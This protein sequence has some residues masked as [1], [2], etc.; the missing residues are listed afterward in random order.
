MA[1]T[2][3]PQPLT[4]ESATPRTRGRSTTP[5]ARVGV[6]VSDIMTRTV[7]TAHADT[8]LPELIDQM[9]H[10]GV[11]GIPIVDSDS[12]LVGIVTEADLISKPAYGGRRHRAL[13]VI[14]D[15][16]RGREQRWLSKAT[17]ATAGQIMSTSVATAAPYET[18]QTAARLMIEAGVKRLPVVD[19]EHLVGIISRADVLR[20]MHRSDEELQGE[21][22]SALRDPVRAPENALVE[23]TVADGVVTL[24]GT[25]PF[26][27]D[28]PVLSAVVWR[29]PGVVDVRNELT[30]EEPNPEPVPTHT[31]DYD[32]F[33]FL[34]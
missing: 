30:P 6:R 33:H 26:P 5:G 13:A 15:L 4:A 9:L 31:S 22:T 34:R 19:G 16:L 12:G 11:S 8:P 10:F 24:R 7:V 14:G 18:V 21:I 20:A 27:I 32:Y 29:F 23:A 17:G 2:T 25:V 28:V 1:I 3:Q